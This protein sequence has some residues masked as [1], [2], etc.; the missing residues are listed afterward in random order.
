MIP[1]K[2]PTF[3]KDDESM[4][5]SQR[6]VSSLLS[7]KSKTG[8]RYE[9]FFRCVLAISVGLSSC[10]TNSPSS[11]PVVSSPAKSPSAVPS[12]TPIEKSSSAPSR[13]SQ[14]PQTAS[15]VSRKTVSANIYKVDNQCRN[16]VSEKMVVPANQ[17][18]TGAVGKV[19]EN[20]D[21]AD[22]S[23]SGYRVSVASGVATIDLRVAPDS[24]RELVSLSSCEQM[25]IFGSLRKTLTSNAQWKI[26]SVRFTNR[27]KEIIL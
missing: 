26:K 16:F 1:I 21:S 12:P 25:A 22:F 4:I 8:K 18:I 24:K 11:A 2:N 23:L 15:V 19:L 17:Q 10:R 27:G 5:S 20:A 7:R 9:L 13:T 3:V 6:Y 14:P